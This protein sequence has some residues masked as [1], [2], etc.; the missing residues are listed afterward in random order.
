[1]ARTTIDHTTIRKWIEQRGGHPA[2]VKA[3]GGAKDPGILRVDFPG[4]S[5]KGTLEA[6]EWDQFFAWFDRNQLA[7]I[8]QDRTRGGQPSRFNK[9]VSRSTAG[10]PEG[11]GGA[12]AGEPR[13][14]T[15]PDAI[16]LLT[17]QHRSV[18][19]M[20][21][22][23]GQERP[24]SAEHR[25]LFGELADALA[26][27][28][29]IE[30]QVFYPAVK[31]AETE[32]ILE[33]SVEEHLQ[34]KR[35]LATLLETVPDG[36]ASAELEELAGLVEEHVIEEEH[37]L[38][39]IVRQLTGAADLRELARRMTELEAELRQGEPRAHIPE[40]TE[41]PAPI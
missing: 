35:V 27:H 41:E 28:T 18:E 14:E 16:D 13:K 6:I 1:M 29:T 22:D 31:R 20:F 2:R 24:G 11:D 39:P 15:A 5:G 7:F 17:S 3:T 19:Q 4:R 30:E 37:E 40:E 23:L 26:V 12:R 32:A 10:M 38:F 25:R 36:D 34:A 21:G 9:L 8:Y 33:E